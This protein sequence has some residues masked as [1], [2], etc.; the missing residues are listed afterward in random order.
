[1]PYLGICLGMQM[2]V[3]EFARDVVGLAGRHFAEFDRDGPYKVIDFM[4]GQSE[5]PTR[6][7]PCAW[8]AAPAAVMSPAP[9][10]RAATARRR[11]SERHRHRYE[12]S[13]DYRGESEGRAPVGLLPGRQ[14]R[15]DRGEPAPRC[16]VGGAVPPGV[17]VPPDRPHPLFR[18]FVQASL[19]TAE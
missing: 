17:Q 15:G 7:G 5:R 11:I 4:P 6:A 1:M 10:W 8:A 12:F 9:P 16:F 18:G 19:E 14:A 13:N 2:A 3:I